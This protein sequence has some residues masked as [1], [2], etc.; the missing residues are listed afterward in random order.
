MPATSKLLLSSGFLR[1]K[2]PSL[3]RAAR[4]PLG[5]KWQDGEIVEGS[6]EEHRALVQRF[7]HVPLNLLSSTPTW[8]ASGQAPTGLWTRYGR[9]NAAGT[10]V[11]NLRGK[12]I[13]ELP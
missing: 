8:Q 9:W 1:S 7:K 2:P 5:P 6:L 12:V 10:K 4:R 13:Y 3:E 11:F